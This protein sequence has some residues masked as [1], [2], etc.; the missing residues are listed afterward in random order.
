MVAA[1]ILGDVAI[2]RELIVRHGAD[3]NVVVRVAFADLALPKGMLCLQLVV[4]LCPH[5]HESVLGLLINEGG[6][7][8]SCA[9]QRSFIETAIIPAIAADNLDSLR[10]LIEV[11]GDRLDVNAKMKANGE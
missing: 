4:A 1:A 10:A 9:K 3:A 8:V 2:A 11:A 6:A 5:E 7:D